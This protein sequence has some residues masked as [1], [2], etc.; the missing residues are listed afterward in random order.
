MFSKACEYAM[1][2]IV[3]VATCTMEKRRVAVKEIVEV[4]GIPEAFASKVMQRLVRAG[5]VESSRGK[6]GGFSMSETQLAQ[7]LYKVVALFEGEHYFNSCLLGLPNCSS[8]KP[9]PLHHQVVGLRDA[10]KKRLQETSIRQ[11][12]EEVSNA[13]AHL[14][15]EIPARNDEHH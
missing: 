3:Y 2:A 11:A 10:L 15:L 14:R 9:C 7:S 12:A 5:M 8:Y 13:G 1:R 6:K 4:T